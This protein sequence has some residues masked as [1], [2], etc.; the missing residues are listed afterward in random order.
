MYLIGVDTGQSCPRESITAHY[1][2]MG[3]PAHR[4]HSKACPFVTVLLP[5]SMDVQRFSFAAP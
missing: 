5:K 2:I 3:V 1:P 4:F